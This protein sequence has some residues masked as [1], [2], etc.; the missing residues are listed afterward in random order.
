MTTMVSAAD[1]ALLRSELER[2]REENQRLYDAAL[3]FGA[4]AE[5]LNRKLQMERL[6]TSTSEVGVMHA[7]RLFEL[8]NHA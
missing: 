3:S 6:R 5:R 8:Q 4:L 1:V 2:L 7:P